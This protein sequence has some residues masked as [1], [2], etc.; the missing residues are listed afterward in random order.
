MPSEERYTV[1]LHIVA[2]GNC[3][4]WAEQNNVWKDMPYSHLEKME[5]AMGKFMTE[6][7]EFAKTENKHT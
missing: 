3:G 7:R 4:F 5:E 2:A 1:S 6:M